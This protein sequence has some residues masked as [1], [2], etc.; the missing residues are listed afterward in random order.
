[1]SAGPFRSPIEPPGSSASVAA[2]LPGQLTVRTLGFVVPDL[3]V[4]HDATRSEVETVQRPEIA[5]DRRRQ[6]ALGRVTREIGLGQSI[7][8][9]VRRVRRRTDRADRIDVDLPSLGETSMPSGLPGTA[10]NFGI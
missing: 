6:L 4:Q 1:M 7:D 9:A 10:M 3:G 2:A 8:A 5:V